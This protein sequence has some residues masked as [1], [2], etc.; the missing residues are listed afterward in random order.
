MGKRFMLIWGLLGAFCSV[1]ATPVKDF[2]QLKVSGTKLVD[3]SGQAV[4]L[5]GM[6]M[7]WNNY[8]NVSFWQPSVVKNMAYDWNMNVI[9]LAMGGQDKDGNQPGTY[10]YKAES[11]IPEV[12]KMVDAAIEAGIY[13]IIDWHCHFASN[14]LDDAKAFFD[15]MSKK[16]GDH[17]NVIYEVWNEPITVYWDQ[18]VNS[19]LEKTI[20]DYA[21]EVVDVI[22][23]NDPDNIVIIGTPYYCQNPQL[24]AGAEV[25]GSNL[26]YA[27]HIYAASHDHLKSNFEEALSAGVPLFMSE[28]GTCDASGAG[29]VDFEGTQEWLSWVDE[30]KISWCNWSINSKDEAASALI[31]ETSNDGI[32]TESDLTESGKI[33]FN[34]MKTKNKPYTDDSKL[35]VLNARY[36]GKQMFIWT[37]KPLKEI[38]ASNVTVPGY[39]I[40]SVEEKG[41]FNENI[42]IT[43]NEVVKEDVEIT[44]DISDRFNASS[45]KGAV[46]VKAHEVSLPLKINVGD[47]HSVDVPE[48]GFLAEQPYNGVETAWGTILYNSHGGSNKTS[49]YKDFLDGAPEL[50]PIMGTYM[51][52]I[53]GVSVSLPNGKYNAYVCAIEDV[54]RGPEGEQFGL[55]TFDIKAEGKCVIDNVDP[56]NQTEKQ[57]YKTVICSLT[58][59]VEDGV[60]DLEF[61]GTSDYALIS[62]IVIGD[63]NYKWEYG[64]VVDTEDKEVAKDELSL[65]LYPNPF[66]PVVN[67]NYSLPSVEKASFRVYNI[68]G[69]MIHEMKFSETHS[70]T[71]SMDMSK[72]ASGV[73]FIKL[74]SPN[75]VIT[76]KAILLK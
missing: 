6:S 45:I 53:K 66:N 64:G 10:Y 47:R 60:L 12:E 69:E 43:L 29:S 61:E 13:V 46:K 9:R 51:Y 33:V 63:E 52:G 67:I 55:H 17:P 23:K 40:Q 14:H 3:K 38:S 32:W 2:G 28:W 24:V 8:D 5:R 4:Q 15:H 35:E 71:F 48:Y 7:F 58:V 39:S 21:Q 68:K 70:N 34:E 56:Y 49:L 57:K 73:Y 62:A 26:M 16:Y 18:L 54:V 41:G 19:T 22:R 30:K 42:L 36:S 74:A 44:V 50:D 20:K 31:P 72:Y 25:K 59:N 75:F 76:K 11:D 65:S 1:F 37:N 27:I